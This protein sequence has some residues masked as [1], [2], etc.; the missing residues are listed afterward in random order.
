MRYVQ[1]QVLLVK[2][3]VEEPRIIF[4][5]RLQTCW[6]LIHSSFM[7]IIK[8]AQNLQ[9]VLMPYLVFLPYLS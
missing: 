6:E 4:Q 9:R 2:L 5:P 7:E 3:G 8:S 1:P